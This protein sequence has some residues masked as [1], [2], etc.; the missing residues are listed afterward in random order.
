MGMI[1]FFRNTF[2]LLEK[3]FT[4]EGAEHAEKTITSAYKPT[5]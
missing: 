3:F 5:V 4:A 1:L 2:H